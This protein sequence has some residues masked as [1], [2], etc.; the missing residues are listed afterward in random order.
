[1]GR[2]KGVSV[3]QR[4]VS[5][6]LRVW[7]IKRG[8]SCKEVA[9]ALGWSESKVSR[10]ETGERGLYEDD[11]SA[12][13]GFLRVPAEIRQ[14]LMDLVRAGVERN[15]H[16]IGDAPI[17]KLVRDLIRFENEATAI[18][19]FEPMLIPGLLQTAEYARELMQ[20]VPGSRSPQVIESMVAARMDRQRVLDRT[21]PPQFHLIIEEMVLHRAMGDPMMMYGQL[22]HLLAASARRHVSIRILPFNAL[23]AIA[24]QGSLKILEC[25][26]QPP[27]CYEESRTTS[28]FLEDEEFIEK[29]RVAWKKISAAARSEEDSRQLIADLA[30]KLRSTT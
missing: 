23:V 12:V 19:S 14:E 20:A 15:W 13:L 25:P 8:L 29:A 3:R 21:N 6:E 30:G 4:R 17:S 24:V 26:D 2:R 1:M 27:L 9:Q 18:Y 10:M 7:R 11:V 5:T 28:T 16:G 22:Q